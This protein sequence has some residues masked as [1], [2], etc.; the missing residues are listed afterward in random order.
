MTP[1]WDALNHVTGRA[2]VKLNH[3]EDSG[4]LQMIAIQAIAADEEVCFTA[5]FV[6]FRY[7][8]FSTRDQGCSRFDGSVP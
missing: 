8:P 7:Y 5:I 2:N 6:R 1:L 3:C 4:E